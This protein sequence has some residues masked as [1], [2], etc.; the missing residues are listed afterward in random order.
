VFSNGSAEIESLTG[1]SGDRAMPF[2]KD[3]LQRTYGG[4]FTFN[5]ISTQQTG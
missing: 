4:S 1:R 3:A 2:E 5:R